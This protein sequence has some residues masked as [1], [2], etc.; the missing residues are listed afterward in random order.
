MSDVR[1]LLRHPIAREMHEIMGRGGKRCR[2]CCVPVRRGVLLST[3]N[4][5]SA[6]H[7][8]PI[9][10]LVFFSN[11][12]PFSLL[13]TRPN[14]TQTWQLSMKLSPGISQLE[15]TTWRWDVLVTCTRACTQ[16]CSRTH[17]LCEGAVPEI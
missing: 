11:L 6:G 8:D 4:T 15:V 10:L 14:V 7:L 17:L 5:R 16:A 9:L 1:H 2:R 12:S 13:A 3:T